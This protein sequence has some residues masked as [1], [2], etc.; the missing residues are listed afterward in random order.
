MHSPSF[1]IHPHLTR[2]LSIPRRLRRNPI[3]PHPSFH[4][5]RRLSVTSVSVRRFPVKLSQGR[6]FPHPRAA[7][8]SLLP[9]RTPTAPG[10]GLRDQVSTLPP[11]RG[12]VRRVCSCP[13]ARRP[14]RRPRLAQPA[15][16]VAGIVTSDA[17][18]S[19]RCASEWT[20]KVIILS[21]SFFSRVSI[22]RVTVSLT[23][24]PLLG[25]CRGASSSSWSSMLRRRFLIL[26]AATLPPPST[27]CI[28]LYPYPRRYL[29]VARD[30]DSIGL[31][32]GPAPLST[33]A[34]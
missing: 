10:A 1:C 33:L 21:I 22:R 16:P 4:L 13:R 26:L 24:S 3:H 27:Y 32:P 18:L 31:A 15:R 28:A 11:G 17:T 14:V 7:R 2:P 25:V 19:S 9:R 29:I 23:R 6:R 8:A 30:I 12:S 5:R 34:P 20:S